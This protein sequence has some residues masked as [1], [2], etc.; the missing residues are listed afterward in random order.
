MAALVEVSVRSRSMRPFFLSP[1]VSAFVFQA[2]RLNHHLGSRSA[3]L[4]PFFCQRSSLYVLF[5][6]S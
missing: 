1:I 4:V 2:Y 5:L 3:R 6:L